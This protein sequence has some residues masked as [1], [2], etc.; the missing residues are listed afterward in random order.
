MRS[1]RLA[2][3]KLV[4]LT[5]PQVDKDFREALRKNMCARFT[6]VLGPGSDGYHEN[7]IHVDLAERRGGHR[8]CQWDVREPP[9]PELDRQRRACA[10]AAA[11]AGRSQQ[12]LT[13][14]ALLTSADSRAYIAA[15]G[16]PA[17]PLSN[18]AVRDIETLVHPYT[19]LAALPR[20]PARW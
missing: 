14:A 4:D 17:M 8:L 11:A 12:A 15:N 18:L 9:G 20:R 1:I 6:T 13:C 2:D 16:N 5:D 10:V 3:G 19:N 7:H